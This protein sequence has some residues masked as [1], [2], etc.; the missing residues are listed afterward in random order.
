MKCE[1]DRL[2]VAFSSVSAAA[3]SLAMRFV[4]VP[5]PF[6]KV[7]TSLNRAGKGQVC[8]DQRTKR[9]ANNEMLRNR[10]NYFRVTF[11]QVSSQF[12]RQ[13]YYFRTF[14][15]SGIVNFS[16]KSGSDFYSVRRFCSAKHDHAGHCTTLFDCVVFNG[17][18]A[19]P[20]GLRLV[21][22]F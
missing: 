5:A 2:P 3:S 1:V 4:A 18:V 15:L 11:H 9:T 17:A 12:F 14:E 6:L 7:T 19:S 8:V 20:N 21:M 10:A 16:P 22:P 13:A